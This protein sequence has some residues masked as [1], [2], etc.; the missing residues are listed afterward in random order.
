MHLSTF[1]SLKDFTMKKRVSG[2]LLATVMG[3]KEKKMGSSRSKKTE[4]EDKP[5]LMVGM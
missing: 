4:R 3:E 1:S 5:S 2:A